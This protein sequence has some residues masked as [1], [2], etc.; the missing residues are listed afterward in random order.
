MIF[1]YNYVKNKV[2]KNLMVIGVGCIV[3]YLFNIFKNINIYVKL[4]EFN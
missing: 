2:V 3:Y 4:V 1:F